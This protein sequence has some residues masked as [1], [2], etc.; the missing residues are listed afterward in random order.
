MDSTGTLTI[1]AIIASHAERGPGNIAI[2]APG[3]EPLTYG[4]LA[5]AVANVA[6]DLH[7]MG[8]ARPDRVAL[9]LPNG[10]E[11][12][13]AFLAVAGSMTCAPLNPGYRADDL[14][15]ALA[16]LRVNAVIVGG[17]IGA[18]AVEA[19][20][21]L[22]LTVIELLPAQDGPAGLFRLRLDVRG[23]AARPRDS[24]PDDVSLVLH[25]SGTTARPKIVPL[26]QRNL[27]R[28]ADNIRHSLAL[29]CT[30]ICVNVMPLFHIH[31]LV[32][33]LLSSLA[34]GAGVVCTRGLDGRD[35]VASLCTSGA[36]WYT[37]VPTMHQ[38]ILAA[39]ANEPRPVAGGRLR[40]VRSASAALPRR[41]IADL[42]A[43]FGVPVIE[44]YG[45]TEAAHQL[46]SNPLAR[47]A[48][49]PG[50]VGLPTGAEIAVMTA[51]G[52][53]AHHGVVGEIVVRGE[54]VTRGYE[55][56]PQ[57]NHA[58]FVDG[59]LRTGDQGCFDA[60]GYLFLTARLKDLINRGGEK[61][62]PGE[63]E[64]AM[65]HHAA[66]AQAV[67][68]AI[69]HERLG[70]EVGAAVVLRPG[71][72]A[73]VGELRQAAAD[74]LPYFKVPRRVAVIDRVP[75]GPTGKVDRA[76]LVATFARDGWP[77]ADRVAPRTA[78]ERR[79][80]TVWARVLRID[81]VGTDDDFFA[82]GGDS[83]LATDMIERVS[84]LLQVDVAL[85]DF[86]ARPTIAGLIEARAR[87]L[88]ADGGARAREFTVAIQ[89]A[90][91]APPIYCPATHDNG[92]WSITRLVR[93]LGDER[94]VYG[95]R[96]PP[97]AARGPVM[98]VEERAARHVEALLRLRPE[99]PHHLLGSC[100]G[101]VVAFE[102]A[103][104]LERLGHPVGLL[105]MIDSF[106]QAWTQSRGTGRAILVRA[107]HLLHRLRHLRARMRALGARERIA[108]VRTRA[109]YFYARHR[110]TAA[111]LAFGMLTAAGLPRPAF[112]CMPAVA[113]RWALQRY[114]PGPY[115]GDVLL[116]R[117]VAPV[118]G[119]Y[120]VP[121]MG[122]GELMLGTVTMLELPCEQ[123]ALWGDDELLRQVTRAI[124]EGLRGAERSPPRNAIDA[125]R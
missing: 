29:D 57:A 61:V 50:S 77:A 40:F 54:T 67:A 88:A 118:A 17:G 52:P 60:D 47:G 33:A 74:R 26:T 44:A 56:N 3:R 85:A 114:M 116:V 81:A 39:A 18:A 5:A 24:G 30:D 106:N 111:Q 13:V 32:G 112:L 83:L 9:V 42:G 87:S 73:T 63:V 58:A 64:E 14:A 25:T 115:A 93:H 107:R 62:A 53:V 90:G 80:A 31:G 122:W 41:V 46:A 20:R 75:T 104:Q 123:L 65:R 35:F 7:A 86:V 100:S 59:W 119:V 48:Q 110:A 97:I 43:L 21:R 15:F 125:G 113:N 102:M 11:M 27:C 45:M 51:A 76:G 99:G 38:A 1:P 69:P 89:T 68:F 34:A 55:A 109:R 103:R 72:Q 91:R 8:F 101:G 105:V 98:S 95:F 92:L 22:S 23:S 36:T 19:A 117:S 82:L 66:V 2:G 16:D 10:P 79:I 121:R 6:A 71:A 108:H 84:A 94:P 49:K 4:G 78:L 120:P 124:S 96:V 28:S 70:E 12:A 37:A